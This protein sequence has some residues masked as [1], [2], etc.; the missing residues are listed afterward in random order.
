V[1]VRSTRDGG[2][3]S[4]PEAVREA[5]L[6]KAAGGGRV[7]HGD[8]K[9][10]LREARGILD[11]ALPLPAGPRPPSDHADGLAGAKGVARTDTLGPRTR[12]RRP[13]AG[14]RGRP[15]SPIDPRPAPDGPRP[16]APQ[17]RAP[18]I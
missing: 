13:C 15:G 2:L 1:Q 8:V 14:R 16:L 7:T 17:N 3:P 18:A 10:A 6:G 4:T 5:A 9:A 11:R 12:A